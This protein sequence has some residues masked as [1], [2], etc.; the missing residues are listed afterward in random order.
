MNKLKVLDV[1]S[2]FKFNLIANKDALDNNIEYEFQKRFENCKDKRILPFDFYLPRF[3]TVIEVQG[4]QHYHPV[5]FKNENTAKNNFIK[6]KEHDK[7]KKEYCKNNNIELLEIPYY[8]IKRNKKDY[9][10]ILSN[11]FI[12]D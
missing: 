5:P 12:K 11:K 1:V 6:T 8:Y 7:I 9:I 4:E 10:K 3:N 2:K